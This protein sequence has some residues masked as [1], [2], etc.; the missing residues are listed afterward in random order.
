L[1][2]S[3]GSVHSNE[4]L[5]DLLS[6]EA[7][8]GAMARRAQAALEEGSEA[9][10]LTELDAFRAYLAVDLESHLAHEESELFPLLEARGFAEEVAEAKRQHSDLRRMRAALASA[11][12]EG[13]ASARHLL[14]TVA[15]MLARH[16]RYEADF[17]Y[18]DLTVVEVERFRESLDGDLQHRSLDPPAQA[19]V[20]RVLRPQHQ[21]R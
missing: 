5:E 18:V 17:M 1:L 8:A 13:R 20:V 15:E 14:G 2:Q 9:A 12:R 7:T 10:F 19:A 16:V 3:L 4:P 21:P 6:E 11:S